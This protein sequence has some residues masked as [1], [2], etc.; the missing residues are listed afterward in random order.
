M[1]DEVTG[2]E[3]QDARAP[4]PP[5][6]IAIPQ[7][8][9]IIAVLTGCMVLAGWGLRIELF[10]SVVPGL[11]AMNPMTA[12]AFILLGFA[13]WFSATQPTDWRRYIVQACGGIVALTGLLKLCES[14]FGWQTGVDRLLFRDALEVIV[15]GR[16][17][18]MAPNTALNFLLLGCAVLLFDLKTRRGYYPVQLLF[19]SSLLGSLLPVVGYIYGVQSF[20]G[21]GSFIPMALHTAITFL[22]LVIGFSF[23]R[24]DRGLASLMR[25]KGVAGITARRLL[26]AAIIIPAALGWL[27]LKGERLGLYEVELGTALVVVT[28]IVLFAVLV[29][30]SAHLLRRIEA[31]RMQRTSELLSANNLLEEEITERNRVQKALDEAVLR[32]RAMVEHALDVICTIDAEGRF[33]TVSPACLKLWGYRPE[34]LIGRRYIELV[35]PEDV[36][37]TN[38]AAASI[39]SGKETTN[40]EN[41]YRHKNGLLVNLMWAAFW[42]KRDGLMFC[43]ARDVTEQ[44]RI[45]QSLRESEERYKQIINFANDIIYRTDKRG[46]FT[47]VNPTAT[48]YL[49]LPEEKLIG[50][51][52]TE[53]IDVEFREEAQRFYQRQ[54]AER[55]PNTY[56][57]F[58]VVI[59]DKQTLWLGQ[60]V[61]LI[62]EAGDKNRIAGF[63]AVA[64]DIS[65]GRR[66]EEVLKDS[67]DYLDRIINAVAD[68]IFVKDRQHRRVLVNDANCQMVGC[69]RERLLSKSDYE[70]FPKAEADVF[71]EKDELVFTTGV[72]SV[73]EETL[74]DA[75]GNMHVLLT[76]KRLY[77]DKKGEQFIVGVIRDITER[78]RIELELE[79]TRDLALES[80][81][82]KSEFLANMSHEIR[83][84]MNGVI[85]MTG[86]LLD[87]DLSD[88]QRDFAE[89]IQSSAD[90][91][92][93]I[94]DDILDFSK[95]EAGQLRFEKIDFDLRVA[96]EA[97]VELLA[98]RAQAKALEF[99]SLVYKDVPTLLRGDPGR[100]R[101]VLTNLLGN[102]V[103]FTERGEVIVC[104]SKERETEHHVTLRFEI[105]D[106]GI[107]ISEE[108]QRRLFRPFTQADGSTTRKYG[109]TGLGLA[110]SKQLVELMGG[111]IGIESAPNV[112]STFWFTGAF[113]K[114]PEQAVKEALP[115]GAVSLEGAR[116]LI[117]DD[118]ATNR[119][120][121]LHQTT[122]WGM[123]AAEAESGMQAI[124]MLRHAA[125]QD[126]PYDIAILDLMMPNMDGFQLANAIKS[127]QAIAGVRLVLLPSFGKRGHGEAAR[128]TGIA[129]Y[130]QKPVRQSQLYNCLTVV[131]SQP[132]DGEVVSSTR[133]VTRHT[134]REVEATPNVSA[135]TSG[136]RILLAEDN[137]VNQKV[138]LSQLQRLGYRADAVPNGRE[139]IKA[140]EK[141]HYDIILM[142]CQMPEMDGYEATEE[143]RRSEGTA[144]R[145]TIIAMTANALESDR[146]RCLTAG[147][148][149]YISKPVKT[150][151]LR[152]ILDR[153]LEPTNGQAPA[154]EIEKQKSSLG[155]PEEEAVDL[156]V[157][158]SYR[159]VE[160]AGQPGLINELIDLFIYHTR[161][162]L[163][164]LR[165]AVTKGDVQGIKTL[166]HT[167]KGG[168]ANIGAHLMAKLG[169]ELE[170]KSGISVDTEVLI[171][172]LEAEFER[173]R[174]VLEAER[175]ASS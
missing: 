39:M 107:G 52:F 88:D 85:G 117:V 141:N 64:R 132:I 50:L 97:P 119:K 174:G 79:E 173:V 137:A 25:D 147:M 38:E 164:A 55:I 44:V 152:Q 166:T 112:G 163:V 142:D 43:V 156:S 70:L 118:N 120:I 108:S 23:A 126:E 87:T 172:R 83:T 89:T 153:W 66:S 16:P 31:G 10:K 93:T 101:Q 67:R 81:R 131:M 15:A 53:L 94:I 158:A 104:V 74:T 76:R 40:F 138:A 78:K 28:N 27:R 42:S 90:A 98:E 18:R 135:A 69:D 143:I 139:A 29:W 102:A 125:A 165:G 111:E 35:T 155:K 110:I 17:N 57:E 48:A 154:A 8:A 127:D 96:V 105:T 60:N 150:E 167:L 175:G 134:L 1:N 109:G 63:Q 99:A 84:P 59:K 106:T 86:L 7:V 144:K 146:Q 56:Y 129:A 19:V 159:E 72:E 5:V 20:Y 157:L 21:V 116:V 148:D 12:L 30:W 128:Q 13:L 49:N 47:F 2:R 65:E 41:R 170:A 100:L 92:L 36:P 95:I 122:S 3:P 73:N 91:L 71:W 103:K 51:H 169:E 168:S 22:V 124:E 160:E 45:E 58:P 34:E 145:T 82:L 4:S 75:N 46:Y 11:V 62:T 26:P 161:E 61:Q 133:L 123:I 68:P 121:F 24:P 77:T 130:L 114:Q 136:V 32:E 162:Q 33:A 14:F 37:K 113:E 151:V 80:V 54:I 9:S 6:G 149:D 115:A 140:L 171:A